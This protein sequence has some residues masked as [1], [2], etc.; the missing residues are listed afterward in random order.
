MLVETKG[1]EE[2]DLPQKMARLRLWCEDVNRLR[3]GRI[4]YDFVYVDQ[5]GFE[6]YNPD[7]FAAL[8]EGFREYK[9]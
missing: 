7:S 3:S 1:R 4:E 5:A 9:D 2:L 6:K 8:M